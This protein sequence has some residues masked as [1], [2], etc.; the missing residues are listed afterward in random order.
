MTMLLNCC[1]NH[2]WWSFSVWSDACM[3]QGTRG[4]EVW[5]RNLGQNIVSYSTFYDA[6]IVVTGLDKPI[7]ERKIVNSFLPISFNICFRFL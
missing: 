1:F 5:S 4:T 7:S 6:V 3:C 2:N